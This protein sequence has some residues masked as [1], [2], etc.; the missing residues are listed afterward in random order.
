M[1]VLVY[2]GFELK[3]AKGGYQCEIHGKVRKFD[4]AGMWKEYIDLIKNEK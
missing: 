3:E 4:T 2:E 1:T